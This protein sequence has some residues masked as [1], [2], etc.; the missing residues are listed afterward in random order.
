MTLFVSDLD[1]T[2]IDSSLTI[3]PESAAGINAAIARGDGFAAATARTPAT[4]KGILAPVRGALPAIVM[5]GAGIFD[6]EKEEYLWLAQMTREEARMIWAAMDE[7]GMDGFLYTVKGNQIEA[8]YR[9]LEHLSQRQFIK[10]RSGTPYKIF[11]QGAPSEG[12]QW[13]F[14]CIIDTEERTARLAQALRQIPGLRLFR[15]RDVHDPANWYVEV[16]DAAASKATGVRFLKECF[17]M[18]RVVAF[19]DNH[20][21]LPLFEAADE[22]YAVANAVPELKAAASG[23]LSEPDIAAVGRFIGRYGK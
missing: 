17:G 4:V 7:L 12:A 2:L 3:P 22:S 21:D 18:D 6:F 15:Y 1:G 13:I 10:A 8:C 11:S 20:N 19:G 5:N 23:V 16:Y 9:R 14:F